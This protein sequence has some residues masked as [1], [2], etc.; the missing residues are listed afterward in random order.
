MPNNDKFLIGLKFLKENWDIKITILMLP[1]ILVII[2]LLIS[3]Y[4]KLK[5]ERLWYK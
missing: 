4:F 5:A 3:F 2:F 1:I